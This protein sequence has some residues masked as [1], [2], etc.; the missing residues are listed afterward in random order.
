MR[1]VTG[2]TLASANALFDSRVPHEKFSA[3]DRQEAEM[4]GGIRPGQKFD[5]KIDE[6]I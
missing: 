6:G 3:I 1:I 4:T 5:D 2:S